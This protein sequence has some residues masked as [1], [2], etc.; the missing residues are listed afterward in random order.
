[1]H[2]RTAQPD[3]GVWIAMPEA[4]AAQSP[5]DAVP[6]M[7]RTTLHPDRIKPHV[8]VAIV[9]VDLRR[10]DL[11][12]VA[13]TLE[14]ESTAVPSERRPGL[15]P[16][17]DQPGLIA[18]FNGGFMAR[19]GHY[20]MMLDGDTFVPPRPDA[21]TVAFYR[22]G[23]LRIRT[24]TEL[25]PTTAAMTMTAFRQTPPCLVE[26]GVLHPKLDPDPRPRKWGAA[27]NG[28]TDIRRSALG[29]DA[30][31]QVLFYGLGEWV[32]AK[33]LADAMSAAGAASAAQLDINWSYTRFLFFG[34]PSPA[35]PLQ[36]TSTLIPKIKHTKAGYVTNPSE[37]DFF[38]LK[39]RGP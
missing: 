12:L 23:P 39:R 34:R 20:G 3:D 38:Y 5:G 24:W 31:G 32:T 4:A 13:G 16:A 8:Y 28:D 25:A 18:V 37:R 36:V 21:C 27:E 26:Q 6:A 15:V 2:A 29:L 9:A 30:T 14:P 17:G 22:D 33:M 11:R 35:E 10:I 1:M 19:H 7:L